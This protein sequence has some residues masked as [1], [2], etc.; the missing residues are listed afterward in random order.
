MNPRNLVLILAVFFCLAVSAQSRGVFIS[1][2]SE[3]T[4]I[5]IEKLAT[6]ISFSKHDIGT[7]K[8][9]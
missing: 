3:I 1:S 2:E 5:A 8:K 7:L 9:N 4:K 6:Q